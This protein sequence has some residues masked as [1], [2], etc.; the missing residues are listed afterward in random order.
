M[1]A[2]P[3]APKPPKAH[4]RQTIRH[5]SQPGTFKKPLQPDGPPQQLTD[6]EDDRVPTSRD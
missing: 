1:K 5:R 6:A 3:P 4:P 2:N